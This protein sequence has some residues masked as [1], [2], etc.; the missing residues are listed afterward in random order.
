MMVRTTMT[1]LFVLCTLLAAQIHSSEAFTSTSLPSGGRAVR[2]K[3][4]TRSIIGFSSTVFAA[5]S[6]NEAADGNNQDKT[7]PSSP[8]EDGTQGG[9]TVDV[10]Y[11]KNN[12]NN[13]TNI[14]LFYN[15]EGTGCNLQIN[16]QIGDKIYTPT[17]NP[18]D[19]LDVRK[20]NQQYTVSGTA[21]CGSGQCQ[22]K[23]TGSLNIVEGGKYFM[24]F[25]AYN[26]CMAFILGEDDYNTLM[27]SVYN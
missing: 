3:T 25:D 26:T 9:K 4:N 23:G 1:S 14:N 13:F 16:I 8:K 10:D 7:P 19:L 2:S 5:A 11:T 6:D 17:S 24:V 12:S 27:E 20:G 21:F 15:D 18:V 22:I